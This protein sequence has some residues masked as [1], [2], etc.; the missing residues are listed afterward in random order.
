MQDTGSVDRSIWGRGYILIIIGSARDG[1]VDGA[2]SKTFPLFRCELG[3]GLPW[4]GDKVRQAQAPCIYRGK[5]VL[6]IT[7]H[8]AGT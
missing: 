6:S 8:H 2:K 7:R 3:L 5:C 4:I 1:M